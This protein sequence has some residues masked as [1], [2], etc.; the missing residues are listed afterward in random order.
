MNFSMADLGGDGREAVAGAR[1][2][3]AGVGGGGCNAAAHM[4]RAWVA[5]PDVVAINTDSQ[6][7]IACGASRRIQIGRSL[8][9]GLSAGGDLGVGKLAAEEDADKIR[10]LVGRYDLVFVVC[11]LGGGTGSGAAPVLAR[12][13]RD[14]GALTIG[15]AALPFS[16]EG[17]RRRK[18]AQE[19]LQALRDSIDVVITLPNQLLP[20]LV[21]QDTSLTEAFGKVDMMVGVSIKM[22]WRLLSHSGI[23]NL[24]FADLRT[25]VENSGGACRFG[26]GEG[27]GPEKVS[28]AIAGVLKGPLLDEGRVLGEAP[29]L[30]VSL[31]GSSDLTLSDVQR[32]MSQ[33]GALA[34]SDVRLFMG[35]AVEEDWQDRV[36][37][38]I[39]AAEAWEDSRVEAS[40]LDPFQAVEYEVCEEA[41]GK[42]ERG[43]KGRHQ[44]EVQTTLKF[45]TADKGRFKNIEPTLY[46]G[47][48]LDLPTY[49]RRGIKLSFEK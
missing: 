28:D 43:K 18:Q 37:L 33:L 16:F 39:L 49:I 10:E 29:A 30:L 1:I 9:D 44:K 23:I 32:I 13:A 7:L 15:F 20:E 26:Y 2:L 14:E 17:D 25:L 19:G 12:I 36:V 31:V 41:P 4:E 8:T 5:G 34:R 21:G 40:G 27:R 22:I 6:A 24:D 35:A 45:D 42:A 3:I 11:S 47:E 38:T 48:D 46:D